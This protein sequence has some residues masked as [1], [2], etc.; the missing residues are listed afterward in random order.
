MAVAWLTKRR[1][2]DLEGETFWSSL[3]YS[4]HA[5]HARPYMILYFFCHSTRFI[6]HF[7]FFFAALRARSRFLLVQ[8]L[9]NRTS[10]RRWRTDSRRIENHHQ[11]CYRLFQFFF[12]HIIRC[13]AEAYVAHTVSSIYLFF[14]IVKLHNSSSLLQNHILVAARI[15]LPFDGELLPVWSA[16]NFDR[17]W[18]IYMERGSNVRV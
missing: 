14:I 17:Q 6:L 12:L 9:L 18:Y 13:R 3:T 2:V 1:S 16:K 5:V 11:L 7:F 4:D 8:Q 15:W 10:H